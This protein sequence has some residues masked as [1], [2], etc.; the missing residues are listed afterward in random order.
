MTKQTLPWRVLIFA[1]LLLGMVLAA[2]GGL[3]LMHSEK[4]RWEESLTT[5][6]ERHLAVVTARWRELDVHMK[7]VEQ[8]MRA[9]DI[10]DEPTFRQLAK[11]V[12][13]A[14]PAVQAMVYLPPA[15]VAG[16]GSVSFVFPNTPAVERIESA[17]RQSGQQGQLPAEAFSA[18][19]P[20]LANAKLTPQQLLLARRLGGSAEAGMVYALLDVVQLT[21]FDSQ[22]PHSGLTVR[23]QVNEAPVLATDVVPLAGKTA[24]GVVPSGTFRVARELVWAQAD[25]QLT[26]LFDAAA[27]GGIKWWPGVAVMIAGVVMSL[28]FG[29]MVWAQQGLSEMVHQQVV[30]RTHQLEQ[31]SR[32]FRLITDNAYDLI[33]MCGTTGVLEYVNSAYHRVLGYGRDDLRGRSLAEIVHPQD[34]DIFQAMLVDVL[35]GQNA[36]EFTL[37]MRQKNG[38][39]V[40]MEGVAKGLHD[41][42]WKVKSIVLHCRDV[43]ARRQFAEDLARSEQRFRDFADSSADWLWE[44]DGA[45]RFTYLSPGVTRVLGHEPAVMLGRPLFAALFDTATDPTRELMESRIQRQQPYR[46]IEFWTRTKSGE[47]VCIRISGV[48]VFK[49]NNEFSGYRGVATNITASKIDRDN[50]FR[51][52]TTDH[53]TGLLNRRRFMEELERSVSLAR[54]HKTK[55]VLMF[56]DLDRFKEINDT[57]GH[58]AGDQI[59][60]GITDILKKSFR[61]TDI[62]A[63]LGGDE[64]AV[65]MHN[66]DVARAQ[67]KVEEVIERMNSFEVKYKEARLS[68]TMSAGMIV[69]PQENKDGEELMMTADLA[70]YRAKDLGRNRM[71]VDVEDDTDNTQNSVRAQLK[72][73]NRLRVCLETG[74]FEMHFQ[75]L[76]SAHKHHRPLFEALLRIYDEDGK[77]GSPALYI[78]AAEHFGL[79][80]ELDLSVVER[81]F[82]IQQDLQRDGIMAD[83]SI[84]LSSRSLGDPEVMKAVHE[85]KDKYT[86]SPNHVMFEVT[87][88]MALLDPNSRRDIGEIHGFINDLRGMGFRFAIDDFGTGFSSFD[89][90]RLLPID[91]V[92]IDG[93]YV[94][95]LEHNKKSRVF[96]EA[97]VMMCH[98]LDIQTVAE[99]VENEAI[100]DILLE[101]NVDYAQGW[102]L[103][104]PILDIR[105]LTAAYTGKRMVDWTKG[106]KVMMPQ[107][108][109]AV[110]PALP[111]PK[112]KKTAEKG[113]TKKM[114]KAVISSKKTKA[115]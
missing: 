3:Y 14:M 2:W 78:D 12:Q 73:V 98:G 101:L 89:Y 25:W 22:P 53:L 104:K 107:P 41:P 40:F 82:K 19:L 17:V 60:R 30:E 93:A 56:I 102:H 88:T 32:R 47:K 70:M 44:V 112:A 1:V 114:A 87:E 69:Y 77:M 106:N 16:Q 85:L 37:R 18:V 26:W 21:R 72:W 113:V 100:L 111:A 115:G 48:P 51:L 83:F 109:P 59:L 23:V 64:F 58:E 97:M 39:Y 55:G 7:G 28:T 43:T 45:L 96:L 52:A 50:M 79:I 42:N 61:S 33:G 95:D 94:K 65:I 84:N 67:A 62:V 92:K 20:V 38:Q 34:V 9:A 90:L 74:D 91:V 15:G 99:F 8:Q 13:A 75:P 5:Q 68:V 10:I 35:K 110:A 80:Q 4:E 66:I 57:H 54:R 105:G 36:V 49:G 27:S 108:A 29:W 11:Q 81:C 46:D 71:F 31:A 76:V 86:F 63:R 6:A 103:G 24:A